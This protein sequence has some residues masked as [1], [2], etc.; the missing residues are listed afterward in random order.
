MEWFLYDRDPCHKRPRLLR[1][2]LLMIAFI[3]I[4]FYVKWLQPLCYI[5]LEIFSTGKTF[6]DNFQT[7]FSKSMH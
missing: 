2:K 5:C 6:P 4:Y 1:A 7:L 3:G